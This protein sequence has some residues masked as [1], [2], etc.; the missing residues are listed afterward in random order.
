MIYD[1]ILKNFK[2]GEP[3][4]LYEI[5]GSSKEVI[6]QEMKRLTDNNKLMRLYNGVYFI[7]YKTILG[8]E[9]K[10][11]INKYIEKK[12][13]YKDNKVSGY[14]TGL[15]L[16]NK[17]GFTSQNSSV[18]EIVSNEATTKQRKIEV[19]GVQMVIYK[20][21]VEIS[22]KNISTLEFLD[23]MSVINKYSELSGDEYRNKLKEYISK[24]KI[25]FKEVRKYIS[26]YPRIVYKNIFE[27]GLM[28]EL[29]F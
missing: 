23:L 2:N 19:D 29:V 7:P 12:Y 3:I 11:S 10:I 27:G 14:L 22:K 1:Y 15:S 25:D 13:L 9:G 4:F 17:C 26:F 6:R 18:Y 20:P 24:N 5:P 28:S 16:V 8:T 21:V